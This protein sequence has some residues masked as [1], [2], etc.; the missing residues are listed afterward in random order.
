MIISLNVD[1]LATESDQTMTYL[2]FKHSTEETK[3]KMGLIRSISLCI[4]P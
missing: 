4:A 2:G 1:Y 3:S